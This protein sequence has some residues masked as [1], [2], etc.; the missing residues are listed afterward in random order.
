MVRFLLL[1]VRL[2]YSWL[3]QS[4]YFYSCSQR[5]FLQTLEYS[6]LFLGSTISTGFVS[7]LSYLWLLLSIFKLDV[8]VHS[9][10]ILLPLTLSLLKRH[11]K[12]VAAQ[13]LLAILS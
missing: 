11:G 10:Y 1:V 2:K 3:L 12:L 5:R 4:V 7:L 6:W 9:V 8:I 13:S